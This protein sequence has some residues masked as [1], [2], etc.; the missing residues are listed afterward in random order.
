MRARR[1][2]DAGD[3]HGRQCEHLQERRRNHTRSRHRSG[4]QHLHWNLIHERILLTAAHCMMWFASAPAPWLHIAVSFARQPRDRSTGSRSAHTLCTRLPWRNCVISP[5]QGS[6]G[7]GRG[8]QRDRSPVSAS[9]RR[10]FRGARAAGQDVPFAGL[11]AR[12]TPT[13]AG[14]GC[15]DSLW[16]GLR[17]MVLVLFRQ[18]AAFATGPGVICGGDWAALLQRPRGCCRFDGDASFS[19]RTRPIPRLCSNGLQA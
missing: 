1:R 5:P 19:Y 12:T 17:N 8:W 9:D 7:C 13:P 10:G 15:G 14:Y 18:Y 11:S 3:T 16:D 6:C 2:A 4:E